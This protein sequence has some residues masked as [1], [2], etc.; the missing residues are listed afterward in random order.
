[1]SAPPSVIASDDLRD[2]HHLFLVHDHAVSRRQRDLQIGMEI[3]RLRAPVFAV[4]EV[5]HHARLQRPR[6]VQRDQRHDVLEGGRLQA[7][8][9]ILHAAR[10][11]LEHGGGVVGLEQS[12]SRAVV[13]GDGLDIE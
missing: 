4:D 8:D 12:E 6:A 10:F 3:F 2:L 13:E 9:Q 11:Q 1:M 5:F 7:L